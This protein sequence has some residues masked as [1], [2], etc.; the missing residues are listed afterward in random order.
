M[1]KTGRS[2]FESGIDQELNFGHTEFAG[3]SRHPSGNQ[4]RDTDWR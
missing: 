4:E 1:G 3:L 2:T